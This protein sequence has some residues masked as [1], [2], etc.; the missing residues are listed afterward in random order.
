MILSLWLCAA[1]VFSAALVPWLPP[2]GVIISCVILSL[3]WLLRRWPW[4]PCA[5]LLLGF[6]YG[7][8]WGHLQLSH[9]LPLALD[10]EDFQVVGVIV[11]LPRNT[12]QRARFVLK[13]ES[14]DDGVGQAPALSRLQLSWYDGETP[15]LG[16]RWQLRVRLRA[17]RGYANPGGF[18]Y[19][20]WLLGAGISATGYVRESADN[21]RFDT[22]AGGAIPRLRQHM[23]D[24]IKARDDSPAVV[25]FMAALVLG[26]GGG[27]AASVWEVLAATGTVHLMVV[28]GLH[29]SMAA[30]GCFLVGL[31]IGRLAG[32]LG[33]TLPAP[34]LAAA[35]A[36]AGALGY[37][38]LAGSGVALQRAVLMTLSVTVALIVRRRSGI[39]QAFSLSLL[40]VAV[41]DPVAVLRP[42]FW[43]SFGAVAALLLWFAP[44]PLAT[45]GGQRWRD[46]WRRQGEAQVVVFVALL[47]LL[48]FFQGEM[49][50]ISPL[51]NLL[52]VPW[53]SVVIVPLCLIGALFVWLPPL[54]DGLWNLAAWQLHWLESGLEWAALY[55]EQLAW[56]PAGAGSLFFIASLAV[57]AA[58]LALPVALHSRVPAALLLTGLLFARPA[59]P[60][61][62]ELTVLDVGQG[63][64]AVV[65]G[66]GRTLVYDTGPA[67]SESFNAGAGIVVPYLRSLGVAEIDLL[68]ISHG[69]N[70]HAGGAV[71]L[72]KAI[73][74]GEI[75]VGAGEA[76]AVAD[77]KPCRAGQ[78]WQWGELELTMLWP[79]MEASTL[80][81]ANDGSC[82]LHLHWQGVDILLP[83]DIELAAEQR[84]VDGSRPASE[85]AV[86]VVLAPHHG[87]RT[88]S[89]TAFIRW[90]DPRHVVFSAG[91]HHHFGH[92]HPQVVER[93]RHHGARLWYTAESGALVFRWYSGEAEPDIT[94]YRL[95]PWRPWWQR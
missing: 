95:R 32:A 90:A 6:C 41:L 94:E 72:V 34:Q 53:V 27:I 50:V 8:G 45:R 89:S 40:G 71:D 17:P 70:D 39:W 5:W 65:R 24:Q 73:A 3:L 67:Y 79:P 33:A 59:A 29:V 16:E 63:L 54:R 68:V 26:D 22:H 35:F 83:G 10:G 38:L 77:V 37:A 78:R 48:L 11:D 55:G 46:Q 51:V 21:L 91:F 52:A 61:P 9:I 49:P 14:I 13:V 82:V 25:G 86:D 69:D 47:G 1:G 30:G 85:G 56:K 88:S 64:A 44:R 84:I 60:A 20:A 18:D 2:P 62:L 28:S 81:T 31:W 15:A 57:V 12:P 87:S 74:P 58:L 36:V 92:P 66:Q 43:L 76:I 7:A 93:Y 75:V 42:G 4:R 19:R 80:V 23:A